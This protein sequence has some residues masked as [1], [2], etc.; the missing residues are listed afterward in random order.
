MPTTVTTRRSIAALGFILAALAAPLGAP[1]GARAQAPAQVVRLDYAYYNPLSLVLRD[2]HWVEE[3]LG[4]DV[5]VQWVQSAGSNKALEYLRGRSLDIGSTAGAAA[6]LGRANGTPAKVIYVYSR[7]EWSALVT[8]PGSGIARLAD[9]KGKRVAATPGTDPFILLLR[10]LA[11]V[12]LGR[13]DITLVP[14]QHQDGRLALDRGDVDAWAGL[15]PFMAQA[16]LQSHDV[17]FFR[18]RA[19][20][21]PGTLLARDAMLAEHPDQVRRVIAAYERARAWARANPDG[22]AT[23]LAAAAR[24]SPDVAARE[25]GRTDLTNPKVD[26]ATRAQIAAAAPILKDSGSLSAGADLTRAQAELFDTPFA[27]E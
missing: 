9:L 4:P 13:G 17:L 24:L 23:I 22:V 25:L 19:L 26:A 2:K 5:T 20:N 18:D 8:K 27:G 3:A 21:S 14:L 11:T 7:P 1:S 10:A 15:D 12:G 6:L 16:E